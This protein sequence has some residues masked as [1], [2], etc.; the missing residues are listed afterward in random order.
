M[1]DTKK[2][3]FVRTVLK[4]GEDYVTARVNTQTGEVRPYTYKTAPALPKARPKADC[5]D[6][7]PFWCSAIGVDPEAVQSADFD[8]IK[9]IENPFFGMLDSYDTYEIRSGGIG[10]IVSGVGELSEDQLDDAICSLA[11]NMPFI[12]DYFTGV[13]HLGTHNP[14]SKNVMFRLLRSLPEISSKTIHQATNYSIS[15][16]QRLAT[17]LRIFIK[18]TT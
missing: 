7:E 3:K 16:C 13:S 8:S 15:Y 6:V 17:A 12:D 9:A 11:D 1:V 14:L 18:L 4:V 5:A 2:S 10:Q